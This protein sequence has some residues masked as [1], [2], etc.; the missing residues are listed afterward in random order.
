MSSAYTPFL[1]NNV[2][3]S[4]RDHPGL[5]SVVYFTNPLICNM[6]CYYCHNRNESI[7]L[8]KDGHEEVLEKFKYKEFI[9][10]LEFYKTLGAELVVISGGEPL[11][12]NRFIK[13]IKKFRN[14]IDLPVRIDTNGQLPE[15]MQEIG[16][17][18][19]GYAVDIKIK[20]KDKYEEEEKSIYEKKLGIKNIYRYIENLNKAIDIAQKYKYSLIRKSAVCIDI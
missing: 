19:D 10:S 12:N 20:I 18:V 11:F 5:F 8:L 15:I 1:K 2:V 3:F 6:G 9:N 4:S 13:F 14:V 7:H 16:T 17:Y